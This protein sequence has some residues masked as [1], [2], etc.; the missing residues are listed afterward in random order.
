VAPKVGKNGGGQADRGA[1]GHVGK[2]GMEGGGNEGNLVRGKKAGERA[3]K[4][5]RATREDGGST[6]I[7][8]AKGG[9]AG[10][11]MGTRMRDAGPAGGRHLRDT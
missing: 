10:G 11:R 6:R 1:G 8:G 9:G 3:T 2:R 4:G 5:V 7:R